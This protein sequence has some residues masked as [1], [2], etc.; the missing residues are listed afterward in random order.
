MEPQ[1][2]ILA[3][4]AGS[5]CLA[6]SATLWALIQRRR[7]EE[8][9]RLLQARLDAMG[10]DAEIAQASVEA[11]DSALLVVEDGRPLTVAHIAELMQA[12]YVT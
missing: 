7:T 12:G 4:S 11:F 8:R 10:G 2:L 9:V 5:I 1:D 3:A 6:I